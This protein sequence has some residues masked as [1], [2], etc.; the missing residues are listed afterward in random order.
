VLFCYKDFVSLPTDTAMCRFIDILNSE[1]K[2]LHSH[3]TGTWELPVCE[4]GLES[5]G[6]EC[7]A[8]VSA[9]P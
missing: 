5:E 9:L 6:G 8:V 1:A 4:S 2:V 7:C 3:Q